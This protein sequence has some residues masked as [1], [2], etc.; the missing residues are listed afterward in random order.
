M[1]AIFA[2]IEVWLTG[3]GVWAYLVAPLVMTAV[4]ILP[5]P[6]EAA[7]MANG[8]L[9]GTAV[10]SVITWV[11]AMTGAWISYELA[12]GWGRPFAQ[13]FAKAAVVAKV[14][15]AAERAGWWGLLVLRFVPVVA[16]TALNWGSG[17]CEIPRWRFLWT[18]AIGITPGAIVFTSA[19]VGLGALWRRSPPF[20]AGILAVVL[21]GSLVWAMNRPEPEVG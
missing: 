5:I 3:L 13:R 20:A 18:T 16:F 14:D 12:R 7:A 6:A 11:G 10:G 9:F 1:D 2:N 19:G 17:L 4:S 21:F 8:V 15:A